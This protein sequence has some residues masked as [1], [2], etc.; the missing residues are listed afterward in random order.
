MKI[1]AALLQGGQM[2]TIFFL[3]LLVVSTSAFHLTT[4]N[5][6]SATSGKTLFIKFY[7]VSL[8]CLNPS[9]LARQGRQAYHGW[10]SLQ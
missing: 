6:E 1:A 9:L 2:T 5:I 3:L 7:A 10:H 4:D 8:L